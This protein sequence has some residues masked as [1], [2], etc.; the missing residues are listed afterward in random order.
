MQNV[1]VSMYMLIMTKI[2][3]FALQMQLITTLNIHRLSHE[4]CGNTGGIALKGMNS[5]ENASAGIS[6]VEKS[7]SGVF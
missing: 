4:S 1:W 6:Q 3:W 5:P 7:F 2:I